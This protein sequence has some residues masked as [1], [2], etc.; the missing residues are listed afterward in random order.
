MGVASA[1]VDRPGAL[2]PV[3]R[4]ALAA[5]ET[6]VVEVIVDGSIPPPLGGRVRSLAGFIKR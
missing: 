3:L 1:V 4:R 2:Q 5:R 6:T